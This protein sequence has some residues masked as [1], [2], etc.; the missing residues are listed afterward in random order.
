MKFKGEGPKKQLPGSSKKTSF[1]RGCFKHTYVDTC[2]II[3]KAP[4]PHSSAIVS[5]CLTSAFFILN[6]IGQ[7]FCAFPDTHCQQLSAFID[8]PSA[9]DLICERPLSGWV[10]QWVLPIRAV[11]AEWAGFDPWLPVC[12]IREEEREGSEKEFVFSDKSI[13]MGF[14]SSMWQ[15][16]IYRGVFITRSLGG[17]PGPDF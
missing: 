5:N 9:A 6:S 15:L 12:E 2:C 16:T 3:F 10:L 11:R 14:S 17:P 4:L 7:Q 8:H 13:P 1:D